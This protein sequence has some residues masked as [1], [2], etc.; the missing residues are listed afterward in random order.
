MS[1]AAL[2]DIPS[3]D[4]LEYGYVLS[5][6]TSTPLFT[7]N[8]TSNIPTSTNIIKPGSG[9]PTI[10][11]GTMTF[12]INRILNAYGSIDAPLCSAN[13]PA[14]TFTGSYLAGAIT[15][16]GVTGVVAQG[17][18]V[19]DGTNLAVITGGS[20]TSWTVNGALSAS[21]VAMTATP[22]L[23]IYTSGPTMKGYEGFGPYLD[24]VSEAPDA[25]ERA[26]FTIE[27]WT[28]PT[29]LYA[30]K[31]VIISDNTI[32]K[33]KQGVPN[34]TFDA[35]M[36]NGSTEVIGAAQGGAGN[37]WTRLTQQTWGSWA[38]LDPCASCARG[39]SGRPVWLSATG[40]YSAANSQGINQVILA[41]TAGDA[42][43]VHADHSLLPIDSTIVPSPI[44]IDGSSGSGTGFGG[45]HYNNLY[46]PYAHG[47]MDGSVSFDSGGATHI[48]PPTSYYTMSWLLA[49]PIAPDRGAG[50]LQ[51]LRV[52]ADVQPGVMTGLRYDDTQLPLN[53]F[54]TTAWAVAPPAFVSDARLWDATIPVPSL[55]GS[56]N[57]AMF[58]AGPNAAFENGP[59]ETDH[60]P[61]FYY[62]AYAVEAERYMLQSWIDNAAGIQMSNTNATS[63]TFGGTRYDDLIMSQVVHR[64]DAW[65]LAMI[66]PLAYLG[67]PNEPA[68]QYFKQ[69]IASNYAEA[70][71]LYPFV[72]SGVVNVPSNGSNDFVHKKL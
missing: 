72:G 26:R 22:S 34:Y 60:Y 23:C 21:P 7:V 14:A 3:T 36:L 32:W 28:G 24:N 61:Q 63:A 35:D 17:Q 64:A 13:T 52:A 59:F 49:A 42:A 18:L 67:P 27:A 8:L 58:S 5:G 31:P 43:F 6:C 55:I 46:A 65:S 68:I 19:N 71:A 50:Y 69:V 44:E 25:W 1:A 54:T 40:G 33:N 10:G 53:K 29:G 38:T 20:G 30:I 45:I 41:P 15:V 16:S 37:V 57:N 2:Q 9:C 47:G 51:N 4:V 56:Y 62:G 48:L 66:G 11:S 12:S 39:A 70:A